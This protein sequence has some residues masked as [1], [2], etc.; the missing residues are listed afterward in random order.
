[1]KT[2]GFLPY[3]QVAVATVCISL[4]GPLGRYVSLDPPFVIFIRSVL[5][6]LF[7]G[8][9]QWIFTK[10]S[11]RVTTNHKLLITTGVV[12]CV[13]WVLFFYSLKFASVA[14]AA[15]SVFT[16]P[17]QTILLESILQK[18]KIQPVYLFLSLMVIAGVLLLNPEF[19]LKNDNTLGIIFGILAGTL[20]A[21]RNIFS[22]ELIR[23]IPS[24]TVYFWQVSI[25]AMLLIP[26]ARNE[27]LQ[28][29]QDN[30]LP[31]LLLG[32]LTTTVGHLLMM[33]SF[34]FFSASEVGLLISGQPVSAIFFGFLILGE[35]PGPEVLSGAAIIMAAVFMAFW[36]I[37]KMHAALN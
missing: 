29:V 2:P 5:G 30:V 28:T 36:H 11:F 16:Y 6:V 35:N 13:H 15:V 4:S 34:R 20:L 23:V 8:L 33:K 25:A 27:T 37:R 21:I 12:I 9:Y 19:S 26:F 17:M 1:M 18:K 7:L 31:L 22:K 3:I 32:L 14:I 24:N 10:E